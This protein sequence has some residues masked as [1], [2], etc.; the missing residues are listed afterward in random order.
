MTFRYDKVISNPLGSKGLG[1]SGGWTLRSGHLTHNLMICLFALLITLVVMSAA[2]FLSAAH[3]GAVVSRQLA[4]E[5]TAV[6]GTVGRVAAAFAVPGELPCMLNDR[7]GS[8]ETA[9]D[10]SCVAHGAIGM[11]PTQYDPTP[12]ARTLGRL[13][14]ALVPDTSGPGQIKR[15]P[16]NISV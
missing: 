11:Q 7:C 13:F 6:A 10:W 1:T 8:D 5:D 12:E 14:P 15:P 9:C 4:M 3:D 2:P 16:R